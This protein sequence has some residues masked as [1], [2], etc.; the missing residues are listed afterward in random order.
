MPVTDMNHYQDLAN[1]A[2][3]DVSERF[4]VDFAGLFEEAPGAF[5]GR[6]TKEEWQ[7]QV[8]NA[9]EWLQDAIRHVIL[10]EIEIAETRLHDGDFLDASVAC[11]NAAQ[12]VQ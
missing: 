3:D 12:V 7:S 9:K 2:A 5:K 8:D 6:S 1:T 11:R 10:M 4:G